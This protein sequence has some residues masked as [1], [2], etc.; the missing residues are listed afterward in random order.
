DPSRIGI[1]LFGRPYNAFVPE[2]NKGIPHKFASRGISIIP[3][4]FLDLGQY[5]VRDHM[6]WSMGQ[7]NLKGASAVREHPQLFGTYITNFSCGPDSFIVGYFRDIMGSKPSLTLEL[8]NHTADAGLETRIEAF[9]D[10]VARYRKL[11]SLKKENKKPLPSFI[12]TRSQL[13]QSRYRIITSEGETVTLFDPRVRL[14]FASINPFTSQAIAAT[15]RSKGIRSLVLPPANE[16]HLKIG[17]GNTSCKECLPLQLTSGAMLKYLREERPADEIT[18]FFYPTAEGPCRFGQYR[19]FMQDL[20]IKQQIENVTFFSP[21]SKDGY[22]G[23]GREFILL[24]WNA[25]VIAD[26]F[27]DIHNAML[28]IA[29]HPEKALAK[30]GD[31]WSDIIRSLEKGQDVFRE[32]IK[33][34]SETLK[35]IPQKTPLAEVPQVLIVGEIYVR[36]E[37]ISRRWLPERLA[38]HGIVSH[39]APIHEWV[40]YV[41]WLLENDLGLFRADLKSRIKTKIKHNIMV[42]AEKEIK[43]VM[44]ESGWYLPRLIDIDHIVNAGKRFISPRL[45]G[46]A[47]LTIGGPLAEVGDE[48]CGAI[49][50]G[51]FGCMPNRLSES[52]L[53]LKMDREHV[54]PFRNDMLTDLVTRRINNL[55]FLAIESDGNP[56]PQVIEARLETFI[57]Q[58]LR[59]HSVLKDIRTTAIKGTA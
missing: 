39:V 5:R 42:K 45:L 56:F 7:I 54:L 51:P 12:P 6:Y 46:E 27:E 48:F 28:V 55:P 29:A 25:I 30:L 3:V 4:D 24:N 43:G 10:I 22:G 52:I 31:I 15:Y 58:A 41:D 35:E 8:D 18:V 17:R 33:Q 2:A 20:V 53:N 32:A 13:E 23:L 57:I 49:A 50:I 44:A 1:V 9:L 36:K 59:L 16:E 37:G 19:D 34:A 11:Q 26:I 14:V 38:A 47:I 40:Y 21:S